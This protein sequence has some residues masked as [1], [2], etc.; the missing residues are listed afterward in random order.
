LEKRTDR[1]ERV[2]RQFEKN[3]IIVERWNSVNGENIP[4]SFFNGIIPEDKSE[5]E[6]SNLGIYENKN[7]LA[8]LLTHLLII[9]DAKYKNYKRVL[10]F[11]RC[12]F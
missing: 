1:W 10:I 5:K 12:H 8:C 9:K 2:K 11:D 3:N 6:L 7:A 4:D